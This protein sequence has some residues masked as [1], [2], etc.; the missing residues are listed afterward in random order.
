MAYAYSDGTRIYWE[1]QGRG[2]PLVLIMGL[3][4]SS[5]LWFRLRPHLEKH[6]RTIVLD[7]R[8]AGESDVPPGPYSPLQM[9]RDVA[10]VLDAAGEQSAHILGYS[11]MLVATHCGGREAQLAAPH[12]A[13]ELF[14]R[15]DMDREQS[16]MALV[17]YSYDPGTPPERIAEDMAVRLATHPTRRGY[18]A[19]LQGL[20]HGDGDQLVPVHNAGVLGRAIAGAAVTIIPR[21]SHMLF[22]DQLEAA[23]GSL[24]S[25]LRAIRPSS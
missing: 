4:Y 11:I 1:V 12:I 23:K 21:A 22:T 7:N 2:E 20:L 10:A 17:P 15:A 18:L 3:G 16:A 5:K 8:G 24:I 9:A 14:R 25:F 13:I 6:F 19:Q